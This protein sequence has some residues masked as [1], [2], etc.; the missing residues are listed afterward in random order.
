MT[1]GARWLSLVLLTG[2]IGHPA[3]PQVAP[4]L[5]IVVITLD[6][7][8]ADYL[9]AYGSTR[10][11]TP[12]L[13][14]L[15]Y[16]G[17]VFEQAVSVA[18]L[19]LPAHCSLFTGLLP[20]R[21]GV[22]DNADG[23]L[24]P[25]HETLPA[26]LRARGYRTSAFVGSTVLQADRGLARGFDVYSDGA[27]ADRWT[28]RRPDRPADAVIDE[29]VEWLGRNHGSPLFMWVHLND[30]HAPYEPP[31]PYQSLYPHD[32]YAGEIAF[33]DS[34]L[35]RLLDALEARGLLNRSAI[36]VA[37][38]HGESLGEHGENEHG[39]FVYQSV[40]RV[41]LI[42]RVP[43]IRARRVS[44]LARLVDVMPTATELAG[45][46]ATRVDGV[47]LLPLLTGAAKS[48]KIDAYSESL[49]PARFGW[50]PVR[51]LRDERFKLIDAPRPELYDLDNDPGEQINL[52]EE[53]PSV[54][55]AL[56]KRI[57]DL[58]RG[59]ERHPTNR[60]EVS[61]DIRDR[62]A[63]L[64]YTSGSPSLP[65]SILPNSADPKDHI[66]R[67]NELTRRRRLRW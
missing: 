43:G 66:T 3:H 47:S 12:N 67:F 11:W 48:L 52:Y 4:G 15:A 19:T 59:T 55:A 7:T 36:I 17:I 53:R 54:A 34:Q 56:A 65:I 64:G 41:P 8:R 6:T 26:L 38:D 45:M 21:H 1:S 9:S 61:T 10:V 39:M 18:P 27:P 5:N 35:G 57:A 32:P 29:A 24:K 60:S 44:A 30:A 31:E 16:D 37:G 62:L 50:S 33:A 49:Y 13:D 40:V 25:E 23:P 51:A 22:R 2:A 63:S 42:V 14:R 20:Q 46:E 28:P 58:D